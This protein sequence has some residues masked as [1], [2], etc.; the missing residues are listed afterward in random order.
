M[1]SVKDQDNLVAF[2]KGPRIAVWRGGPSIRHVD[3]TA[4]LR[5]ATSRACAAGRDRSGDPIDFAGYG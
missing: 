1:I 3:G 4:G 2:R 5:D